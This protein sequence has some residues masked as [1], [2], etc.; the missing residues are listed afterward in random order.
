MTS[1]FTA[2]DVPDQRGKTFLI[3]GANTGIG[4]GAA[5]V[6]AER[7]ARV[8]LGCRSAGRPRF[9][10]RIAGLRDRVYSSTCETLGLA[11]FFH[12]GA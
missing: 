1:D 4:F 11:F 6:L 7:G 5:K 10:A 2:A 8:P 3:T 12:T 9:A